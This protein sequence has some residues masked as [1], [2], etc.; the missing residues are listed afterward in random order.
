VRSEDLARNPV[1]VVVA[2]A[3]VEVEFWHYIH[4]DVLG[5][6]VVLGYISYDLGS[7]FGSD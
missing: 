3:V 2:A 5:I 1:V 7:G 6:V 4:P